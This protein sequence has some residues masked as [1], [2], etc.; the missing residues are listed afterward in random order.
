MSDMTMGGVK[1]LVGLDLVRSCA[2]L[3]VIAGHFFLNTPFM[4][5]EFLGVSMHLQAIVRTFFSIGVPLFI[6]LTGYLNANKALTKSYF[7]GIWRV[8]IAYLFFSVITILFREFCLHEDLS[9]F[10]WTHKVLGY[11]AIPYAWYIEMWIGLFLVIPFLNIAYKGLQRRKDKFLLIFILYVLTA[12]PDLFNR[13]GMHI[14][15]GYWQAC[16]P[17]MFYFAGCYIREYRPSIKPLYLILAIAACCL[18]NP[19]F[20]LLFISHRPL[21]QVAGGFS[22]VFGTIIA[23]AFFSLIYKVD[24]KNTAVTRALTRISLLSLDMYL[25][26]YI[27]D[28]IYYPWFKEHCYVSQQQFGIYFFV[29]VPLVFVS[30]FTL[31]QLKAWLFQAIRLFR[32]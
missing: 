25:C 16:Y 24:V 21:L 29:L 2:I 19:I 1:R 15:P 26:S 17:L 5:T 31:A 30:S 32:F 23:I 8:L 4:K 9:V 22:G 14:V 6:M 11:S 7:H 27:F 20:N 28:A 12:V 18:V 13:Y 10:Q 3:F